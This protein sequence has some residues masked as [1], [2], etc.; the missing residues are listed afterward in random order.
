MTSEQADQPLQYT[1]GLSPRQAAEH[2]ASLIGD[3]PVPVGL[4]D[5]VEDGPQ[6]EISAIRHR[7]HSAH[8]LARGRAAVAPDYGIENALVQKASPS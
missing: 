3:W 1:D 7:D 2:V 8:R 5:A 4:A 6:K